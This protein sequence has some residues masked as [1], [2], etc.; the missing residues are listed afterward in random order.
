MCEL[1]CVPKKLYLN[2]HIVFEESETQV[3]APREGIG[4][5]EFQ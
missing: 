3:V 5:R 4:A 2:C 1:D